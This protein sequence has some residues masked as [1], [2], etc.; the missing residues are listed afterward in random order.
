[1]KTSVSTTEGVVTVGGVAKNEAEKSLVTKLV[2]DVVGV[3]SVVN[4]MTIAVPVAAQ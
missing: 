1:L 2:T 3:I 4:N